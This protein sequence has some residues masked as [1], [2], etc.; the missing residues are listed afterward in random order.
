MDEVGG[1][2]VT[3]FR[4]K[5]IVLVEDED[6]FDIPMPLSG[7]VVVGNTDA[8][9]FERPSLNARSVSNDNTTQIGTSVYPI[10]K[11]EKDSSGQTAHSARNLSCVSQSEV[12]A[13]SQR[14][15][16]TKGSLSL[17]PDLA[18]H[19]SMNVYLAF[20]PV[21]IKAITTTLME[22]WLVNDTNYQLTFQWASVGSGSNNLL[23]TGTIEPNSVLFL[24]EFTRDVYQDI[25]HVSFQFLACKPCKPYLSKPAVDAELR[26]DTVKFYKLHTFVDTP[27][28]DEPAL[29]YDIV[30]NDV[31]TRPTARLRTEALVRHFTADGSSPENERKKTADRQP[32]LSDSS[33]GGEKSLIEVDLH[34]DSLLDDTT[35]MAS[36]DI[37]E[38]QLDVFRRTLS[39]NAGRKGQ[40]MVFIHGKGDG[41]LRA[42]L[43]REL[44]HQRPRFIYQ[45]ASFQ[46]YG[47]GAMLVI[48]K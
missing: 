24:R 38:Y 1:G 36:S 44:E 25:E 7:V 47:F 31:V 19:D 2:V 32:V 8:L 13:C 11:G 29:V 14:E 26:I 3:G 10:R 18:G 28:F 5:D 4:G 34:I 17:A 39:D 16:Q 48:V 30:R 46:R 35:G 40:R 37:L 9:N 20:L 12:D 22:A 23:G 21:D 6:G 45:D 33:K 42:A 43:K 41:V 15:P 27:F